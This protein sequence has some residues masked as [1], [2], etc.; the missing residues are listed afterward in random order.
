MQSNKIDNLK[1]T[2][3]GVI[4]AGGQSK[5]MGEPKEGVLLWDGRSMMEHLIDVLSKSCREVLIVGEPKGVNIKL[6]KDIKIVPDH[7]PGSGPLGGLETI[8][9]SGLDS[10]YLV[11]ACDQPLLT[12]ELV[13][14]LIK[15]T[16]SSNVRLF[17]SESFH[18]VNPFPGIYPSA[19][20]SHVQQSIQKG[21]TAM[22]EMIRS[23]SDVT[24]IPIDQNEKTFLQNINTPQDLKELNAGK[25]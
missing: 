23:Y 5:R 18:T 19:L 7:N 9:R 11:I 24:W 22:H 21:L 4:L 6:R 8:L 16:P 25:Q 1:W 10:E 3:L 14:K 12:I 2:H 15:S 20:L 13:Q 17:T